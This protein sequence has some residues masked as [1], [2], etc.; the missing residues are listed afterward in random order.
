M[1]KSIQS[2]E[3]P[4]VANLGKLILSK[5]LMKHEQHALKSYKEKIDAKTGFVSVKYELEDK[6]FGRY[7]QS[8]NKGKYRT[9]YTATSMRREIRNALFKDSYDD[10]DISNSSGC[11]MYQIFMKHKLPTK[12]IGYYVSHREDVLRMIMDHL[13]ITRHTAKDIMIEIFFCG[14]GHSSMYWELVPG[15]EYTLPPLVEDLK[16]EFHNNLRQLEEMKEYQDIRNYCIENKEAKRDKY[17]IG[18]FSAI[19][20]QDEERKILKVLFEEINRIGKERKIINPTGG[21]IFDGL[22][23]RKEMN[24]I[25][26][27]EQLESHIHS[28]TGYKLK[29]EIKEMEMTEE[30]EQQYLGE[31][32]LEYEEQRELFEKTH[33]KT[34]SG[35]KVF[36]KINEW[37]NE[38]E[39]DLESYDKGTFHTINED[40]FVGA[41]DFLKDWFLDPN[42]RKYEDIEYSCVKENEKK[43]NIYYAFPKLRFTCLESSSTS[44]EKEINIKFFKEYIKGLVEDNDDYIDWMEHWLADIIQNP[45]TKGATP[46]SVILY[47]KAGTGKSSLLQL[48]KKILGS[49]C[50]LETETPTANGNIFH[51]F[52]SLIKYKLFVEIAEVNMRQVGDISNQIKGFLTANTHTIVHKGYDP[53]TVKATERTLFTT[54]NA[55][56]LFIEKGDRRMCAFKVSEKRLN[57]MKTNEKYWNSVYKKFNDNN[58]IKDISEYLLAINLSRY[59]LRDKRPMTDY[60]NSLIQYSLPIELDYLR[61]KLLYNNTEFDQYQLMSKVKDGKKETMTGTGIYKISCMKLFEDFSKWRKDVYKS[62]DDISPKSFTIKM[63]QLEMYGITHEHGLESNVFK[64]NKDIFTSEIYKDFNIKVPQPTI[65][66]SLKSLS[67]PKPVEPEIT[68]AEIDEEESKESVEPVVES[69]FIV[70][71]ATSKNFIVPN[72]KKRITVPSMLPLGIMDNN[73]IKAIK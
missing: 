49:R 51:E 46:I 41:N 52:N 69:E 66:P 1:S 21:L 11:I 72:Q 54:N 7:K 40:A 44:E 13:K 47:S 38:D 12:F 4:S 5:H 18:T 20:Y 33:F 8:A 73:F 14:S 48:M 17:W 2:L 10:L 64:I 53:I 56:N 26:I 31:T 70:P 57:N 67:K 6:T 32:V 37:K 29:L 27:V 60:Y 39:N 65:T 59:C 36:H 35:K 58:F 30:D 61:E 25:E 19:L 45:D 34:N 28:K 71:S 23:I 16:Q 15:R 43:S 50:V 3:K 22:H 68:Y 9:E 24:I 55:T 42:K 63:K 62:K